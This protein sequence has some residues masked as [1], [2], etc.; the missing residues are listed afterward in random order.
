MLPVLGA[1]LLL[2]GASRIKWHQLWSPTSSRSTFEDRTILVLPF[3]SL[4]VSDRVRLG[5]GLASKIEAALTAS[6]QLTVRSWDL[7]R[8]ATPSLSNQPPADEAAALAVGRQRRAGYIL[9][10]Q[11]EQL[12]TRTEIS[13]RCAC[14]TDILSGLASTGGTRMV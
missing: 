10:G 14:A 4:S 6:H 7:G 1:A 13:V 11:F 12:G 8:P 3:R 5:A 2:A 9:L